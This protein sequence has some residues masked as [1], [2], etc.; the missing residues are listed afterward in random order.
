MRVIRNAGTDRVIDLLRPWLKPGHQADL[1]TP[2]LSLF[3]FGSLLNEASNLSRARLLLPPDGADLQFLGTDA[4]RAARNRMQSR[5]L[6]K[7]CAEWV[8]RTVE[9]RRAG[10]PVP[11]GAIVIRDGASSPQQA[12]LGSFA[13]STDGLGITPGNPL[14]LI[15]ASENAEEAQRLSAW[16]DNQVTQGLSIPNLMKRLIDVP[17]DEAKKHFLK[18]SS[19]FNSDFPSYIQVRSL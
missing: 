12:L 17:S 5:W 15:Q 6:A 16:F 18:G 11:Q 19:Y 7:R 14:S 4:D 2:T 10:G 3:A 9:S 1:V 8:E 13:F